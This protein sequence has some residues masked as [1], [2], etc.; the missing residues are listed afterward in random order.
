ME[1][2]GSHVAD[3]CLISEAQYSLASPFEPSPSLSDAVVHNGMSRQ[4]LGCLG[5]I[6]TLPKAIDVS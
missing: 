5:F 4:T 1:A 2:R 3:Q 6:W